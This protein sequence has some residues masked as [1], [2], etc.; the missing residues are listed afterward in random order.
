M[1][2]SS[3]RQPAS[4]GTCTQAAELVTFP[5]T[6]EGTI[7]LIPLAWKKRKEKGVKAICIQ[8]GEELNQL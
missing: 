7:T 3:F 2:I 8:F 6:A 1:R 5:T 4:S